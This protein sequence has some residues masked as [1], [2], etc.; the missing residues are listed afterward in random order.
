MNP[1]LLPPLYREIAERAGVQATLSLAAAYAGRRIYL[2]RDVRAAPWL[3]QAMGEAGA[4]AL[5]EMFGGEAIELP[6]DPVNGQRGRVRRIR[7]ALHNG[8]SANAIA[9][10]FNTSR[11]MIEWHRARMGEAEAEPDLFTPR[12]ER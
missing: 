6:T 9:A 11:R 7:E 12:E 2:P 3:V 5:V 8:E 10:R 4:A 1:A